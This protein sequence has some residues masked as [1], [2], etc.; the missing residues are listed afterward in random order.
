MER[1]LRIRL[2]AFL[3]LPRFF[4]ILEEIHRPYICLNKFYNPE[5]CSVPVTHSALWSKAV[6][7]FSSDL[8]H[9][10]RLAFI[11]F[12]FGSTHAHAGQKAIDDRFLFL[13]CCVLMH[14]KMFVYLKIVNILKC[15]FINAAMM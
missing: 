7:K 10:V 5:I 15:I 11:T 8:E 13:N 14:V 6:Q 4:L 12:I 3:Q 9:S 1:F 2:G